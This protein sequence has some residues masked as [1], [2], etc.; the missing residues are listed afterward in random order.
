[1]SL[2]FMRLE[3][4]RTLL[5][6]DAFILLEPEDV[7]A[8]KTAEQKEPEL[9]GFD[10]SSKR[11]QRGDCRFHAAGVVA[12][13]AGYHVAAIIEE[14]GTE[15][16][17]EGPRIGNQVGVDVNPRGIIRVRTAKGLNGQIWE[18]KPSFLTTAALRRSRR[19][20]DALTETHPHRV[21][22]TTAIFRNDI[23]FPDTQGMTPTAFVAQS[24][25]SR[26]IAA[27]AKLGLLSA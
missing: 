21:V 4:A 7:I 8:A 22:G 15:A 19:A 23:E 26:S 17:A 18:L 20:P 2:R 12:H 14:Y 11:I 1:M 9:W 13:P 16:P 10:L 6:G 27:V 5:G 24:T 25:D 3:E